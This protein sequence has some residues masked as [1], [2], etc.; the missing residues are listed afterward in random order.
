MHK[1]VIR[2]SHGFKILPAYAFLVAGR[3]GLGSPGLSFLRLAPVS[4]TG[5]PQN[6]FGLVVPMP[7]P[8]RLTDLYFAR[9]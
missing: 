2:W 8:D 1:G 4:R 5:A 6:S 7:P 9:L 3:P